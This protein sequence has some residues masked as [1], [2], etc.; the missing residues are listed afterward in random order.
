MYTQF[1]LNCSI[2]ATAKLIFWS[3]IWINSHFLRGT[4]IVLACVCGRVPYIVRG[5]AIMLQHCTMHVYVGGSVT[6]YVYITSRCI[7]SKIFEKWWYNQP[8]K[9][10]VVYTCL[11][12][13]MYTKMTQD[14]TLYYISNLYHIETVNYNSVL[15]K[16][17]SFVQTTMLKVSCLTLEIT[18]FRLITSK[19]IYYLQLLH[20]RSICLTLVIS[21]SGYY[22]SRDITHIELVSCSSTSTEHAS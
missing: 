20:N 19:F 13:Y 17:A 22:I 3:Q 12:M 14:I 5:E 16:H 8:C 4:F 6:L 15:C 1:I 7:I 21:E 11:I 10:C 18:L 9:T 2:T